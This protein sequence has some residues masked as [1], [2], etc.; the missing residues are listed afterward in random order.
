M[1]I[2]AIALQVIV[3]IILFFI[4]MY[5][6]KRKDTSKILLSYSLGSSII[7]RHDSSLSESIAAFMVGVTNIGRRPVTLSTIGFDQKIA[8]WKKV[9]SFLTFNKTFPKEWNIIFQPDIC[10]LLKGENK[11]GRRLNES[12]K[13]TCSWPAKKADADAFKNISSVWLQDTTDKKHYLSQKEFKLL[14]KECIKFSK[15]S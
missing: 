3:P 14:V 1:D 12:E 10:H 8:C 9:I 7:I 2:A 6:Q 5:Y 15:K 11:Q 4:G 13:T